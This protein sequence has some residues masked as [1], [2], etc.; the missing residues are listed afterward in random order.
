MHRAEHI[1]VIQSEV[2]PNTSSYNSFFER[3]SERS[4][5]VMPN[6]LDDARKVFKQLRA[7]WKG[8]MSGFE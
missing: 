5:R 6:S 2:E 8:P 3:F 7:G 1:A 4:P